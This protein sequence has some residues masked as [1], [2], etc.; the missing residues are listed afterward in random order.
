LPG[1][2]PLANPADPTGVPDFL[3]FRWPATAARQFIAAQQ[4]IDV[5]MAPD[6]RLIG[7]SVTQQNE[8]VVLNLIWQPEAFSGPYDLYVHV[9]DGSGKQI[10]Q[11][12]VLARPP[13]DGVAPGYVLLTQHTLPHE[14]QN[15]VAL[16]GAA[17]RSA[18]HPE[19][20]VGGPIGQEAR[21]MLA[22]RDRP[23]CRRV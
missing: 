7:C 2:I 18:E 5:D 22:P 19:Q 14:A 4:P 21:L 8:A 15:G 9:L 6:V 20:V 10:A 17:H 16:A 1:L 12:D 23:T 3:A 11:S 13:E